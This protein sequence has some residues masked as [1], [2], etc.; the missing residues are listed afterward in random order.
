MLINVTIPARYKRATN[1][2]A[3]QTRANFITMGKKTSH[4]STRYKRALTS[5]LGVRKQAMK[6]RV[7][8]AP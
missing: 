5:K 8:N 4:E 1:K 6:V 3:L 7:T 2:H